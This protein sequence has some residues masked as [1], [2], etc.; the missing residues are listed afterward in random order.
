MARARGGPSVGNMTATSQPHVL[1]AGGGVAALEALIALHELARD[2][3][4]VTILAPERDFVYRPLA[5][6]EPFSLGHAARRELAAI[7]REFGA[8][9]VRDVLAQV[10]ADGGRVITASGAEIAYDSLLIA[11]GAT[12][13]QVFRHAITFDADGAHDA[14][15]GLLADLERGYAKRVAFVVPD[16][17]TWSLPLYEL[18]ILTARDAW[19]NGIDGVRLSFV[20]PE[21]TPLGRLDPDTGAQVAA[22]L[23]RE[24]V[25]FIG[26]AQPDV[27]AGAVLAGGLRID[28][29]RVVT[30]PVPVGPGIPGLP[31][32]GGGFIP[33][34]DHA[35]VAGVEGVYA[36]GDVT[37]A[38][39]KQGG[40]AA[41]QA[42]AAAE[43]IAARH[44]ADVDP[45]PYRLV[46]RS[47]LFT[48][49][50]QTDK[51]ASRYLAPYLASHVDE[52][53]L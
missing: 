31:E 51:I 7:A 29:D 43:A 25:E 34:D 44:G 21:Q 39:V 32:D 2:R 24:G 13:Q 10:D 18:A 42:L 6:A 1:I 53:V 37:D 3:V 28:V 40:L 27:V 45:Q 41:Q 49:G 23:A 19:A 50:A 46:V 22:A 30:L 36:A 9:L 17:Q 52:P 4:R 5:V 38:P 33:V 12:G 47:A 15:A 35:R 14:L 20:T 11:V 26:G 16:S 48:G 8:D